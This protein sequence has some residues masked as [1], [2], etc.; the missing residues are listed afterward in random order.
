VPKSNSKI[1]TAH[2]AMEFRGG[3]AFA[4]TVAFVVSVLAVLA[5]NFSGILDL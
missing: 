1:V 4:V 3:S 5:S 2:S